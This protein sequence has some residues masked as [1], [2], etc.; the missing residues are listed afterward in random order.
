MVG[1]QVDRSHAYLPF[2]L[3]L[4]IGGIFSNEIMATARLVLSGRIV[5]SL[6]CLQI[7][8]II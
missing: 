4:T 6:Q 7:I 5:R 1:L 8:L 2:G 3:N